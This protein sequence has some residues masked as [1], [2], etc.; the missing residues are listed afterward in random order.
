MQNYALTNKLTPFISM[1]N[2]HSL[3]YREEEREMFPT[4][5][6]F[7]VGCIPY[8]P[9]ARGFLTRPLSEQSL[10]GTTDGVIKAFRAPGDLEILNRVEEIAK[11]KGIAMAQVAI[12]WSLACPSVTAPIVGST[13]LENLKQI[14]DAVHITL[15]EDEIKYLEEPYTPRQVF[16]HV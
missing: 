13:N 11:K 2:Y 6:L 16:G 12:A 8:S 3:I 9:L 15:T 4:T 5:K 7:G 10:R 1:Q 14:I